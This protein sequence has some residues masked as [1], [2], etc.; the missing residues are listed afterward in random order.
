MRKAPLAFA[1]QAL[2]VAGGISAA[3]CGSEIL[4]TQ[5]MMI[6]GSSVAW[7]NG[8]LIA[9]AFAGLWT[10]GARAAIREARKERHS[11]SAAS[12]LWP[13]GPRIV[14]ASAGVLAVPCAIGAAV[15]LEPLGGRGTALLVALVCAVIFAVVIIGALAVG[16]RPDARR[17]G[18]VKGYGAAAV[19]GLLVLTVGIPLY[20]PLGPFLIVS[21]SLL[22]AGKNHDNKLFVKLGRWFFVF[23]LLA[24][25]PRAGEY[26]GLALSLALVVVGVL[27]L[28]KTSVRAVP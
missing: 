4:V 8:L 6:G 28:R 21:G 1:N 9:L 11:G 26:V 3:A 16:Y 27:A 12:R 13:L 14:A 15:W 5:K 7:V 2:I 23:G 25:Y 19:F 10:A 24:L 17:L 20:F 18:E 22:I